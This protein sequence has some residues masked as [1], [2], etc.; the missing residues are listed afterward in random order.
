MPP[1]KNKNNPEEDKCSFCGKTRSQVGD[2]FDG[3]GGN[4]RIC[5]QCLML[6]NIMMA[7]KQDLTQDIDEDIFSD[8]HLFAPKKPEAKPA[9]QK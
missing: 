5:D 2:M 8:E 1:K 4:V 9:L 3:P 7:G 6:C